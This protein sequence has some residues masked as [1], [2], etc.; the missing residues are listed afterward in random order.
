MGGP[1]FHCL[2]REQQWK[3]LILLLN[4]S[5]SESPFGWML[6]FAVAMNPR[7]GLN[8]RGRSLRKPTT[9]GQPPVGGGGNRPV[10]RREGS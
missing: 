9:K 10:R 7:G 5:G 1:R 8:S 6:W 3:I 2:A 4:I